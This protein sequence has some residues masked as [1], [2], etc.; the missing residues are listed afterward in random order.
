VTGDLLLLLWLI[1]V[2]AGIGAMQWGA[3][4]ASAALDAYRA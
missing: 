1:L 2:L 3:S 4:R